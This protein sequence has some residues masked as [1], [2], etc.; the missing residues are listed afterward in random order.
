[1]DPKIGIDLGRGLVAML[2]A[3]S[4]ALIA[5]VIGVND[6]PPIQVTT[7]ITVEIELVQVCAL[8]FAGALLFAAARTIG[9]MIDRVEA[10]VWYQYFGQEVDVRGWHGIPFRCRLYG[11]GYLLLAIALALAVAMCLYFSV[12][13]LQSFGLLP[14]LTPS[15]HILDSTKF[16]S[17]LLVFMFCL[18]EMMTEKSRTGWFF[19]AVAVLVLT[20]SA[21]KWMIL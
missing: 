21:I 19:L 20:W 17:A 1:M 13:R 9:W 15:G 3:I 18:Y 2:I 7:T 10:G 5:G 14:V 11:G 4:A 6:M 8:V 12:L 16:V